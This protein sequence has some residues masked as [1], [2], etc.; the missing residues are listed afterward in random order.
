MD[1]IAPDSAR[2]AVGAPFAPLQLLGLLQLA[3]PALPVGAYSYSQGLESVVDN[4]TVR[5]ENSAAIWIEDVMTFVLARLEG[6]MLIRML[7]AAARDA[8][9]ELHALNADFLASRETTEL[10]A[11]TVQMGRS[12][13]RL[14]TELPQMH[15]TLTLVSALEEPSYPCT[16]ACAA[17]AFGLPQELAHVAYLWAWAENQVVAAIKL[18]PLGQSAGQRILRRLA[19]RIAE[20]GGNPVGG[21]LSNFA[22]GLAIAS[23]CHEVQY[24]RLFRS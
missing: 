7:D 13:V 14:F 17:V 9:T 23:S 3:S 4:G 19:G 2:S 11:E 15:S 10:R 21:V 6:P 16:W 12:L 22:P 20:I 8:C 18:V 5:D 1:R 24:S